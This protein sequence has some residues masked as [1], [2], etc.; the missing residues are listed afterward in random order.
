MKKIL[1]ALILS[2]TSTTVFANDYDLHLNCSYLN[3]KGGTNVEYIIIGNDA[4]LN[5]ADPI[6]LS[7][8]LSISDDSYTFDI[9]TIV[10]ETKYF[11]SKD[12]SKFKM[13]SDVVVNG[14][15]ISSNTF[16]G[17]CEFHTMQLMMLKYKKL[18]EKEM[19]DLTSEYLKT[20]EN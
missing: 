15:K 3:L 4:A 2:L 20:L 6:N 11:V 7:E 19:Q 13:I 8:G 5:M 1:I 14:K 9:K 12:L 17:S 10:A 16:T 18:Q